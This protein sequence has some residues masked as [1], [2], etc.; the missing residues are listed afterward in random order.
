MHADQFTSSGGIE[1]ALKVKAISVD[2]LEALSSSDIKRLQYKSVIATL[3]PGAS[4][5]LDMQ[6]APAREV[7]END[8]PV[9]IATDFNPGS[10]MTENMQII[11]SLASV[12]M[13][14]TGEEILNA[15]TINA[16]Y[17]LYLQELVGS[18]EEGKQADILIFDF[19]NYRDL[20]YHFGVN[21]IEMVIKKGNIVVNNK[22]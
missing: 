12:K 14:M 8:I 13:K 7:I 1:V 6:Y 9:A 10:C 18:I 17:A 3:L 20:L 2:H 5:F 21:Q 4:Y 16:A 22:K 19:Q 11:M 15:V